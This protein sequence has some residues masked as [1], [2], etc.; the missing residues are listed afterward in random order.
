ML[1]VRHGPTPSSVVRDWPVVVAEGYAS[2]EV[3]PDASDGEPHFEIV[4][5]PAG[6]AI[7]V[8]VCAG[9]SGCTPGDTPVLKN[10]AAAIALAEG[11]CR[12]AYDE[13]AGKYLLVRSAAER[14]ALVPRLV[15]PQLPAVAFE[16]KIAHAAVQADVV[17][18]FGVAQ[19]RVRAR[20]CTMRD[21]GGIEIV[22][23]GFP[24]ESTTFTQNLSAC[25]PDALE[26]QPDLPALG[27][28]GPRAC[29]PGEAACP[30]GVQGSWFCQSADRPCQPRQ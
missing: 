15:A 18:A 4:K 25:H 27:P 9:P 30:G 29:P 11:L 7:A 13:R 16:T 26:G 14:A 28:H 19:V 8:R 1:V 17:R 24:A 5:V 6:A 10:D 20:T 23:L 2:I 12:G 22:A 3:P 21:P